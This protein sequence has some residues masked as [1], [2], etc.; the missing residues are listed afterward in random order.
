MRFHVEYFLRFFCV[1]SMESCS[2]CSSALVLIVKGPSVHLTQLGPSL[3]PVFTRTVIGPSEAQT[4]GVL[5]LLSCPGRSYP[6]LGTGRTQSWGLPEKPWRGFD[7][8]RLTARIRKP[9]RTMG[10]RGGEEGVGV[11][12]TALT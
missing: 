11:K 12:Y 1:T 3:C 6:S 8:I 5:F 9:E 4:K 2:F 7:L 10:R